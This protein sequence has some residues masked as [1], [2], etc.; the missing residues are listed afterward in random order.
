MLLA[1]IVLAVVSRVD[2]RQQSGPPAQKPIFVQ[3]DEPPLIGATLGT[4]IGPIT[5]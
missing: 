2:V 1:C 4:F 3:L 5:H